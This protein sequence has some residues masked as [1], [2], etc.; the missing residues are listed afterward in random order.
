MNDR[1]K[2]LAITIGVSYGLGVV[3]G[4]ALNKF[5]RKVVSRMHSLTV[6]VAFPL[7]I[8][9]SSGGSYHVDVN[10]RAAAALQN[11]GHSLPLT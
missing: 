3:S 6:T 7:S 8:A 2:S 1:Q 4:W 10:C 9:A 11:L 5:A